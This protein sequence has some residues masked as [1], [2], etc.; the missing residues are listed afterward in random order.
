MK[1]Y[2]CWDGMQL[3]VRAPTFN[4]HETMSLTPNTTPQRL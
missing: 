4:M 1:K 3:S 2:S